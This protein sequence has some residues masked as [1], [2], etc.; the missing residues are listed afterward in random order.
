MQIVNKRGTSALTTA[1]IEL[2]PHRAV[3]FAGISVQVVC[4]MHLGHLTDS[5]SIDVVS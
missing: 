3:P 2:A 1:G 5:C 4:C